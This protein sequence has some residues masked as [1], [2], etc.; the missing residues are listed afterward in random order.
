M[1]D[2]TKTQK[3]QEKQHLKCNVC[4][5]ITLAFGMAVGDACR[6]PIT[7]AAGSGD[8]F[9]CDGTLASVNSKSVDAKQRR[10]DGA[11]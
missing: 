2:F 11:A 9:L 7:G 6:I 4:G 1:K 3:K 8:T 5:V 10:S